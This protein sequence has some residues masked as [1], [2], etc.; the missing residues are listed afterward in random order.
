V[1][2]PDRPSLRDPRFAIWIGTTIALFVAAVAIGFVWL[3]SAQAGADGRDFWGVICSAVGLPD[4]SARLSV[5][6]AGQPASSIAWTPETR[7][8]L[9][10]GNAAH[11]AMLA[12]TCN[13]CHGSA[14]VSDDAIFPNL[15]GQSVGAI[16]KQLEDFK[17]GKRDATV[18]GVY[19]D[20]L[21]SQDLRDLAAHFAG[22]PSP[23]TGNATPQADGAESPA[24][25][26]VEVGDPLRGIASC[27]ACHGPLGVTPGAPEL[28]GQQRGYFEEQ[29]QA[30][31]AGRRHNDI[32]EQMRT[33]AR[34]LTPQEISQLAAYYA[35]VSST[36]TSAR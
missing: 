15:A 9:T 26:L 17:S 29:L 23:F 31:A 1:S 6:V 21:S 14:G 28:R 27:A 32:S 34:Q 5:A 18:M 3:P 2:L 24:R 8:L 4:R 33:V 19:V 16:Y 25:R 11:G 35:S 22:L 30:L 13:N 7:V 10:Q 36:R 12:T 20:A